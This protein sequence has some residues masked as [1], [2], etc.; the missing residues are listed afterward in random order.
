MKCP[1]C[2][3]VQADQNDTCKKCGKDLIA[4]KK[5]LGI[6]SFHPV[7]RPTPRTAA[8]LDAQSKRHA[9]MDRL[10]LQKAQ[11]QTEKAKVLAA[12]RA[13]EETGKLAAER[14]LIEKERLKLRAARIELEAKR[15]QE[16]QRLEAERKK[17][18]QEQLEQEKEMLRLEQARLEAEQEKERQRQMREQRERERQLLFRE[19]EELERKKREEKEQA[20]KI[21]EERKKV[22]E[23]KKRIEQARRQQGQDGRLLE[24]QKEKAEA[25]ILGTSRLGESPVRQF[26]ST[27]AASKKQVD[28]PP[29]APE[30]E[31]SEQDRRET[32]EPIPDLVVVLKGGFFHRMLA[33]IVDLALIGAG[34]FLFLMVGNMVFSWGTPGGQGLGWKAFLLLTMPVYILTVILASGYF[35]YFHSSFGQ[36]PGKKLLRLKLV[37][38]K[39]RVPAYSTS[40]LRFV[41]ALFCLLFVGMGYFWIGLDLNKQGWHDKISQTIVIRV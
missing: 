39:G 29:E 26:T 34:L 21:E 27:T 8:K 35:T 1:K 14:K 5:K 15:E 18:Q 22:E 32:E 28:F 24:E 7:S 17:Q 19:K 31:Q 25:A 38:Y 16:L 40:F 20:A 30:F 2:G 33:G 11:L 12:Q 41:A 10:A 36:T 4:F 13:Q 3:F 9:E 37:D 23:E 6:R